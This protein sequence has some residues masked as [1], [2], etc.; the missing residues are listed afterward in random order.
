MSEVY[1]SKVTDER[2][3]SPVDIAAQC[4]CDPRTSGKQMDAELAEVFAE[5]VE[6]ALQ[7]ADAWKKT[8]ALHHNNEQFWRDLVMETGKALGRECCV[9]D[10]GGIVDEPLGLRVPIVARNLVIDLERHKSRDGRLKFKSVFRYDSSQ[11]KL[12]LFRLLWQSGVLGTIGW[13]SAKLSFALVPRFIG[14]E[15]EYFGWRLTFLG[16]HLH[17]LKA[18]GGVIV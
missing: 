4:W 7:S 1:S 2:G 9:Q 10:D 8:A 3:R 5:Q 13:Y 18:Y 15:R 6:E 17:H 12:R 16:L 11:R 14:F